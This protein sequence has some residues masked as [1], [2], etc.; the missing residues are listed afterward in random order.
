MVHQ[1]F[2]DSRLLIASIPDHPL[3]Y[4]LWSEQLDVIIGGIFPDCQ[5]VLY[6]SRDSFLPKYT[7]KYA[8][9][10]VPALPGPSGTEL[11]AGVSFPRT[12][13]G[14]AGAIH[15]VNDREPM[16]Y[17]R[18]ALAV[19][20]SAREQVLL[21]GAPETAGLLALF[22]GPMVADDVQVSTAASRHLCEAVAKPQIS[23][24]RL[25]GVQVIHEPVF[26]WTRDCAVTSLL[27]AEWQGTDRHPMPTQGHHRL[28]WINRSAL[29]RVLVP[30]QLPLG[31][32]L[33]AHW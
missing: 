8:T 33:N 26:R 9:A 1:A 10:F 27:M 24:P 21:Y 18:V 2:P 29:D 13:A 23:E 17:A 15:A 6:G 3:T 16:A 11:R 28:R 4:E 25:L 5:A 31:Q 7:G 22:G 19:V 14:R 12:K 32:L 20:D 30:W